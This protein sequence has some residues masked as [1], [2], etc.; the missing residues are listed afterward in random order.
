MADIRRDVG[1]ISPTQFIRPAVEDNSGAAMLAAVGEGA[2]KID[3]SIAEAQLRDELTKMNDLYETSSVA[4]TGIQPQDA[5]ALS[6]SDVREINQESDRIKAM[7]EAI[8]QGRLTRDMFR[9]RAEASL[10]AAIAR[11]PGLAQEFRQLAATTLGEDVTGAT[12]DVLAQAEVRMYQGLQAGREAEAEARQ[13]ANEARG[14][15]LNSFL[16][17]IPEETMQQLGGDMVS[18]IG[19]SDE[20]LGERYSPENIANVP[21]RNLEWNL[22]MSA[23]DLQVA[24]ERARLMASTETNTRTAQAP[25]QQAAFGLQVQRRKVA[26]AA[27]AQQ[28]DALNTDGFT[29]EDIPAAQSVLQQLRLDEMNYQQTL[30]QQRGVLDNAFV[31]TEIDISKARIEMVEALTNAPTDNAEAFIKRIQAMT[32]VAALD[33]PT[34]RAVSGLR[35]ILGDAATARV[36]DNS[37]VAKGIA[38]ALNSDI[39]RTMPKEALVASASTDI[40]NIMEVFAKLGPNEEPTPALRTNTLDSILT[41][42]D[43]FATVDGQNYDFANWASS[44]GVA[45]RLANEQAL[46][47]VLKETY[48]PEERRALVDAMLRANLRNMQSL[49]QW[50]ESGQDK[51]LAAKLTFRPA[52]VDGKWFFLNAKEGATLNP[53]ELARVDQIERDFSGLNYVMR[54]T[55]NLLDVDD[56]QARELLFTTPGVRRQETVGATNTPVVN[57][58]LVFTPEQKARFDA[59][60]EE[61]RNKILEA[62]ARGEAFSIESPATQGQ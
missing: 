32:S 19:M 46:G 29:A 39:R 17:L 40:A 44:T 54:A 18:I 10:R 33:N 9:M 30:N 31:N 49:R 35:P 26:L 2:L 55:K 42:L 23:R 47:R 60:P 24:E 50:M 27:A 57:R 7:Q 8:A 52:R 58:Q 45:Q 53:R 16:N 12:K 15:Q 14:K 20:Q 13:A 38:S 21:G 41:T 61:L 5:A 36:L 3:Q 1:G 4:I 25:A 34:V 43:A 22:I 37:D 56:S 51:E 59:I 11:R 48:S 28:L 62:T 6:P